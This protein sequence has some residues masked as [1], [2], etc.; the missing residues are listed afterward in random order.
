MESIKIK[1]TIFLSKEL[2]TT[3]KIHGELIKMTK[4]QAKEEISSD[5]E[6]LLNLYSLQKATQK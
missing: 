2:I 3:Q 6:K 1:I 4:K 5:V